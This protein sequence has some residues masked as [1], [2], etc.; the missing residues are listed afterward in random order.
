MRSTRVA[1]ILGF[2]PMDE[3]LLSFAA[4]GRV[5]A[6]EDGVTVTNE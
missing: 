3:R 6:V 5:A 4:Q 1:C 2:A